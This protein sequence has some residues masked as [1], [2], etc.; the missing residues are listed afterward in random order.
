[1]VIHAFPP[2][3]IYIDG[4]LHHGRDYVI[5]NQSKR[6]L[7]FTLWDDYETVEGQLID[8]S[9]PSMPVIIAIKVKV[10]TSNCAMQ[11]FLKS[12]GLFLISKHMLTQAFF[13]FLCVI[14]L[15]CQYA[16]LHRIRDLTKPL[17]GSRV[18]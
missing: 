12:F 6:P 1:M 5:V 9:M 7:I 2:R 8:E 10:T 11:I 18:V 3:D 4:V 17:L 16:M 14:Q 13:S 15:L